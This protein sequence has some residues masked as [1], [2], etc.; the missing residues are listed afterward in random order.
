MSELIKTAVHI[1]DPFTLFAFLAALLLIA[2]RTKSVPESL[3]KLLGQKITRERFYQLLHRAFLYVFMAFLVVCGIAVLG[4]VL[5]YMTTARAASL[6]ELKAELDSSHANDSASRQAMEAYQKGL[7]QAEDQKLSDA[8]ASL[9]SSIQAVPTAAARETLALLYQK[10]GDT[11]RA[12]QVATQAVSAARESGD[13]VRTARAERLLSEVSASTQGPPPPTHP[14]SCPADAG[15]VGSKLDL[16]AGGD[17]FE[18]AIPILP[19]VYK[20]LTDAPSPQWKFYKLSVPQGKTVRVVMR[21]RDVDA[22]QVEIRLHNPDGG[23]VG[24]YTTFGASYV[25]NPLEYKADKPAIVFVSVQ[26]EVRGA[27][28]D[29]SLH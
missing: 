24:G 21:T 22:H 2:F 20:G 17:A 7:A 4:Q 13:A 9:E 15:L 10:A 18:T 12:A 27:A 14:K 25:T 8:I 26:G 29:F 1:K 28:F 19:C 5:G 23:V 3:F 6:E 16:P 11:T